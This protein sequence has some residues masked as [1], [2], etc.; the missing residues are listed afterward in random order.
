MKSKNEILLAQTE[1]TLLG[2]DIR[3]MLFARNGKAVIFCV[4]IE[5]MNDRETLPIGSSL[6]EATE[7]FSALSEGAVTPCT[8]ADVV[9]D[10]QF[11]RTMR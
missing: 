7:I 2:E 8:L 11:L 9:A 3:Y 1:K 4:T 6:G 5:Y 10:L